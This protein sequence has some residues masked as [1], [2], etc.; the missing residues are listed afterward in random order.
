M[1]KGFN[2]SQNGEEITYPMRNVTEQMESERKIFN[3][4]NKCK[5]EGELNVKKRLK[6]Q[7]CRKSFFFF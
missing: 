6:T 3:E 7:K 5:Y 1:E 2:F 4:N